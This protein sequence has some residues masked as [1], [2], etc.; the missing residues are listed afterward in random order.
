[1]KQ[2]L[3]SR[4]T[5]ELK[6]SDT[7]QGL[8]GIIISRLDRC[9]CSNLRITRRHRPPA[10]RIM[11][12]NTGA[13]EHNYPALASASGDDIDRA[14]QSFQGVH[15]PLPPT[16]MIELSWV[17]LRSDGRARA[18][19]PPPCNWISSRSLSLCWAGSAH[20]PLPC[21]C[22]EKRFS[23]LKVC[24]YPCSPLQE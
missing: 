16:R 6:N 17:C 9:R 11:R 19:T 1:M 23:N 2:K 14:D 7:L 5:M 24:R 21:R 3:S 12:K 8:A 13:R 20:Q 22:A 4:S 10:G 15:P 18:P